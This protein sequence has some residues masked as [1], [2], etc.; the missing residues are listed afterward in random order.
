MSKTKLLMASG[1]MAFWSL[2]LT[3]TTVVLGA[4]PL[5]G[6]RL[7]LGGLVYWSILIGLSG[8]LVWS[9]RHYLAVTL[10]G[11][12]MVVGL[13]TEAEEREHD[14]VSAAFLSVI[15]T[16]LLGAG[17][18]A[19]W[20]SQRGT[21]W[22][23]ELVNKT[24]QV[25]SQVPQWSEEVG[26]QA[27]DIV[28]RAPSMIVIALIFGLFFALLMEGRVT[29]LAGA[30]INR[31]HKLRGFAVPDSFIWFFLAAMAGAFLARSTPLLEIVCVNLLNIC[32]VVFFMQGLAVVASYMEAFKIGVI[33]HIILFLM[34]LP[35]LFLVMSVIMSVIGLMDYWLNLRERMSRKAQELD[36]GIS[37]K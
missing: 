26:I 23:L 31:R 4:V 6:M 37:K 27:K 12:G 3:A 13:F 8:L 10:L 35:P 18:L 1:L 7:L 28:A 34:F 25:L 20:I 36:Q 22:Y 16:A 14:L 11:L 5:R 29:Q 19:L 33:G 30:R 15:T 17:S 32:V 9:D 21:G 2:L 24:E